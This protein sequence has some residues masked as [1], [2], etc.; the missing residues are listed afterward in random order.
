MVKHWGELMG[1]ASGSVRAPLTELSDDEKDEL[2][3]DI[4]SVRGLKTG[5]VRGNT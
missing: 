4:E 2:A 3:G 5:A 1:M